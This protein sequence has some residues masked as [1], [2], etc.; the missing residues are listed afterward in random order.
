MFK[1]VT[2]ASKFGLGSDLDVYF[3][4]FNISVLFSGVWLSILT[5]VILPFLA[6]ENNSEKFQALVNNLRKI[7]HYISAI[8]ALCFFIYLLYFDNFIG[9][10]GDKW[11]YVFL[12]V[13]IIYFG[14]Q[15]AFYSSV[16]MAKGNNSNSLLESL[17]SLLTLFFILMFYSAKSVIAGTVFGFFLYYVATYL[18]SRRY[19][20][21]VTQSGYKF[22][23]NNELKQIVKGVGLLLLGQ[24]ILSFTSLIDQLY[25]SSI[26]QG[27]LTLFNYANKI[28]LILTG[29]SSIVM[30]RAF[31]PFFSINKKYSK[32]KVLLFSFLL[33]VLSLS[34]VYYLSDF[35]SSFIGLIYGYGKFDSAAISGVSDVLSII[36]YQA[37][38][39][40]SSLILLS[41]FSS[42]NFY[43]PFLYTGILGFITKV[44]YLTL[45]KDQMSVL[46]LAY[47]TVIMYSINFFVLVFSLYF[48]KEK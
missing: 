17:P 30:A 16:L 8:S 3:Y 25:L 26:S 18:I 38:F 13:S 20:Y 43:Y 36:L 40:V 34:V 28:L 31:I 12:G 46:V 11:V 35:S 42:K 21:R 4:I 37:P 19:F 6:K 44:I 7:N 23:I 2:L 22:E 39:F 29:I 45:C 9:K 41:Y 5:V 15:A 33:L 10:V 47:S 24:V 48:F 32:S 27:S 1:D 14:F